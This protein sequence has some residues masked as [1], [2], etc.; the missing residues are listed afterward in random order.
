MIETKSALKHAPD[1]YSMYCKEKHWSGEPSELRRYTIRKDGFCSFSSGY[2]ESK[3]FTRPIVF[4]GDKLELN[5]STSAR[6]Y[7]YITIRCQNEV[8]SSCELFGDS[9][10]RIVPFDGDLSAFAG[11]EVTMEFTLRDADLYSFRFF[12]D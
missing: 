3:I 6:G 2:G 1:E 8:I 4:D 10:D 12:R 7:V 9:L 5:F 11:K